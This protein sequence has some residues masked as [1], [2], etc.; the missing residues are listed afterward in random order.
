MARAIIAAALATLVA[1]GLVHLNGT[2]SGGPSVPLLADIQAFNL[3][4]GMPGTPDAAW[5]AHAVLGVLVY[6][7]LY[8]LIQP[9]LPESTV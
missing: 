8:A 3:R 1:A 9:I 5:I 7:V 4:I 2:V 6:G